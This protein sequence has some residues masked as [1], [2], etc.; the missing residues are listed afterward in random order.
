MYNNIYQ[1]ET[2]RVNSV[3]RAGFVLI[4]SDELFLRR[5]HD[6]VKSVRHKNGV[7]A[8]GQ[9][10]LQH[11]TKINSVIF[12][13]SAASTTWTKPRP[14]KTVLDSRS[15]YQTVIKPH[16]GAPTVSLYVQ[17]CHR[18]TPRGI[19]SC[20]P[21]CCVINISHVCKAIRCVK[22]VTESLWCLTHKLCLEQH[23]L[24]VRNFPFST[25]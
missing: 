6:D 23:N 15:F 9:S 16:R 18:Q 11:S 7:T 5:L 22:N 14:T 4:P 12:N 19:L 21:R 13:C 3:R 8:T 24:Y 2:S 25:C 10:G 20:W 17:D 1:I